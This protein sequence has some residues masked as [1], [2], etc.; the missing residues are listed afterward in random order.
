MGNSGNVSGALGGFHVHFEIDKDM[1]GRPAY[2]YTSCAEVNKGHYEIIQ[3]G[4]CRVQLFQYTKDPIAL[5]EGANAVYPTLDPSLPSQPEDTEKTPDDSHPS[6]SLPEV[7]QPVEPTPPVLPTPTPSPD[8]SH[9]QVEL[10][11]SKVDL[12]GKSF[13]NTWDIS[14]EKTFG[15]EV[16]VDKELHI[17]VKIKHKMTGEAFH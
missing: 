12:V 1:S 7:S 9:T 14:L 16:A 10:D 6:P 3:K 15:E 11:F 8:T 5:L 4:Y 17:T 13:L 2:V